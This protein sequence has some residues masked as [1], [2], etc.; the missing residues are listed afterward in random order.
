MGIDGSEIK[1]RQ[2]QD[3]EEAQHLKKRGSTPDYHGQK[4]VIDCA[5]CKLEGGMKAA[6]IPKFSG[7]IRFIGSLIAFPS[8][9]GMTFAVL[10]FF[11]SGIGMFGLGEGGEEGGGLTIGI[12]IFI[13][14][15]SA[16]SGLIGWLLL[17]KKNVF[18]CTRCSYIINRL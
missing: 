11:S 9:L 16:V 2:D 4:F 8:A 15:T 5:A 12:S 18:L 1:K 10:G 3:I 17:M 14:C 7:F 13:F 6:R